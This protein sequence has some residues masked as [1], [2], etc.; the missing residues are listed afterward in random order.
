[1]SAEV[2]RY[3]ISILVSHMPESNFF[4]S[5]II[6]GVNKEIKELENKLQPKKKF[7]FKNKTSESELNK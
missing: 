2:K 4:I 3:L 6:E 5:Q 7:S 1:M